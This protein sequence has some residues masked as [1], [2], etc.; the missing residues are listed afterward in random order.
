MTTCQGPTPA[1]SRRTFLRTALGAA[2][3]VP[4][5][6]LAACEPPLPQGLPDGVFALGVASGDPLPDGIVLWTRLA[7]VPLDGGGMPDRPVPVR[8]EVAAD[9]RFRR[10]VR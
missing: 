6:G 10:V 2:A 8:W 1:W 4:L 3:S 5:V 9:E 7:P